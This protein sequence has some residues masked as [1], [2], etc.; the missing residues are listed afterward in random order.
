MLEVRDLHSGYGRIRILHGVEM[1]VKPRE[2]VSVIGPNGAG[3]STTFKT[4]AGFLKPEVGEARFEG[5][6]ITAMR[7]DQILW[8]GLVYVPQGRIVFHHMSVLE[9]L[10]MGG[11]IVKDKT[12]LKA[13]LERV[14]M[15]FSTLDERRRQMAGILSGGGSSRC[16]PWAG[17]S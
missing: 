15:L 3:K 13:S 11:Y 5:Q 16:W 7:A 10:E 17:P 9:N 12:Q 2:I 1:Y 14:Y 8:A 6:P 4:I